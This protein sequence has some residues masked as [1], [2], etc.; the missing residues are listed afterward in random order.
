MG[1]VHKF[2]RPPKNQQQFRGYRPQLPQRPDDRKPQRQQ[3]PDW[4]LSVIAWSGLVLLATAI[5]A[6]NTLIDA[7]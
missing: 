5:W 1:T 7:T 4:L 6:A 3:V 2:K